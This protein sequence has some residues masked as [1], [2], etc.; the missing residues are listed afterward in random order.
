MSFDIR[1]LVLFVVVSALTPGGACMPDPRHKALIMSLPL[2]ST[3]AT[4]AVGSIG[5]LP[6]TGLYWAPA[7]GWAGCCA[8]FF[9][10]HRLLWRRSLAAAAEEAPR[11]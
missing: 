2:P 3:A 1:D 11:A 7:V 10:L 4:P 8:V 5:A 9:P 6:R